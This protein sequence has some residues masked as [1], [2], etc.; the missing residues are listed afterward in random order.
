M[1]ATRKG[2]FSH[3]SLNPVKL[4]GTPKERTESVNS[5]AFQRWGFSV[6]IKSTCYRYKRNF[7]LWPSRKNQWTTLLFLCDEP[8][9][10]FFSSYFLC[11]LFQLEDCFRIIS[12]RGLG[13]WVDVTIRW[14]PLECVHKL[15]VL[16]EG[17]VP[18]PHPR[19][20]WRSKFWDEGSYNTFKGI[21]T[22]SLFWGWII[23]YSAISHLNINLFIVGDKSKK[24]SRP[25]FQFFM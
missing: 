9:L 10:D 18:M 3:C 11:V 16:K 22:T 8:I 5:S 17:I 13:M 25:A 2:H 21:F 12:Y 6:F 19:V 15:P 24:L 4:H 14:R 7:P 23:L 20:I 1:A